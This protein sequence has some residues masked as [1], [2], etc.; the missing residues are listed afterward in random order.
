MGN[1]HVRVL[2]WRV[3]TNCETV[4]GPAQ[5]AFDDVILR[6]MFQDVR[7]ALRWLR[8][9]P[10]FACVALLSLALGIGANTAIFSL[11]DAVL[12]KLLPVKDP[13][14]LVFLGAQGRDG[15]AHTFYFETYQRLRAEQP[16]F[17]DLAAF[18]PVRMNVSV[19]GRT[20]PSVE[21]QLVSGNYFGV[22]GAG[23]VIG[24]TLTDQDDRLPGAH[25]VAMISYAYWQRRFGGS[26]EAIGK[27]ILIDG[28]PFT[29]IGVTSPGFFGL[30]VGSAPDVTAPLMM[31]PQVMPERE[32]WLG[33]PVNTVDWLRIAGRL[34]PGVTMQ[35]ASAG[36]R[37]IY[38]RVQTQLA[39]ELNSE[40]ER[41]WLKE[42]AE[43]ALVLEPGGTGL[44]DLRRQFSAPLFVLMAVVALVLLMACVNIAN[45]LL[46]RAPARQ[47]EIAVRLA[48]GAGRSRLVRQLL[49]E[50]VLLAVLGGALGVSIAL[51]GSQMLV[52]F[53]STGRTPIS[54]D[55]SPDFRVLGFTAL[56]S[57]AT[58]I[59]FGLAPAL[60]A[61]R[62]DLTAALKA[63]GYAGNP[64]TRFGKALIAV[65]VALSLVLVTG[66]GLLVKSL[67]R[68]NGV[69]RGFDRSRVLTVRLEP[70]GSDQ[71]HGNA[72]RLQRLYLELQEKV[73]AVPGVIA[74]GL[75]GASP[76]APL[77]SRTVPTLDGH[78]IRS[79]WTQVYPRYFE[80]LGAPILQGRDFGPL[81]LAGGSAYVTVINETF[82]KRAFAGE[83][84]IGKRIVCNGP[85]VCEVIGV[86][87]D[88]GYSNL[89]GEAGPVM[90]YTFLQGPTG[91]AQMV[92]HVRFAG[93]A[94]R[95]I[96]QVRSEA[97][98]VDP[99]LPAFE[100]RTLETE[101]D[102]ALIRERL[103]ALLSTCFGGL[104]VLLA[105]VGLYGVMTYTVA[106]RTNE[107]GI[108]M[109]L[110]ASRARVLRL[111]LG[112]TLRVTG[113]G[114]LAGVPIT[115]WAARLI[116]SFL[117][118]VTAS[119]PAVLLLAVAFLLTTAMIAGYLP[120]RRASRTDP[121]AALRCE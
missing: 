71:K 116:G 68:L 54:L 29:I 95:I 10:G 22:T 9:S 110:G 37:V 11:I 55:L 113:L 96:A 83:N 34:K 109:A 19:D 100:I 90:Y 72:L 104:A 48:I 7:Y 16:F 47:R 62:V 108:R 24:R 80:T 76:T 4:S 82:A 105:V 85:N 69:D 23:A 65:Q 73:Q 51:W 91:R 36:M 94:D 88:I 89:K 45:L 102:A 119:D 53:L 8:R 26:A 39:R 20:E 58:G 92:L 21:G 13:Q 77:Q 87:P 114:M 111:V 70:R 14:G 50:S 35:Q 93:E 33:R 5:S 57:V 120:A 75:A 32:N 84:P 79:M 78:Q 1:A 98:A 6:A 43:A 115:L 81:D 107:I 103:L 25:P 60:R 59:L 56:A 52:R 67:Q 118:R 44:S 46:A 49:V 42:W 99:N 31:Q 74:A 63:G 117:Y 64:N 17:T 66:A 15:I 101:V 28:T 3:Y 40:W 27:K 121:M 30:E 86:V 38:R 18:S 112:E 2:Q 12:L 41:T 61:A 106:R 97:A